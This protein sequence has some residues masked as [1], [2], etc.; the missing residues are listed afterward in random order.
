MHNYNTDSA[1]KQSKGVE[2]PSSIGQSGKA[3]LKTLELNLIFASLS[4]DSYERTQSKRMLGKGNG[5][6]KNPELSTR[7]AR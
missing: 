4:K 3:S 2:A 5:A 1:I 7:L 6:C